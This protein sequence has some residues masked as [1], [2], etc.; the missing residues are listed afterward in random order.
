MADASGRAAAHTGERSIQ[1]AGH[2][3]GDGFSTQANLMERPV[4]DAM[5]R[6]FAA[7]PGDLAARMLVALEAAEAEG[8]DIRGR[9]SAALLVVGP[10]ATGRSWVDRRFDLRVEDHPAPVAE[11]RRLVHLRRVYRKLNEGDDL[12]TAGDID[13]ATRAYLEATN[14]VPDH[15][16]NGEAPF[17]V[18][19]TLAQNGREQEAHPYLRRALDVD[20]CWGEVL[21]RLPAAG[22]LSSDAVAARLRESA[23][24]T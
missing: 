24:A 1:A 18:G 12:V 15:A 11:L 10:E 20:P 7:S 2:H 22:L 5:A 13:A 23:F 21:L 17:W 8:G 3:V 16:T 9:Q 6:A 14:L 19:V 4:W